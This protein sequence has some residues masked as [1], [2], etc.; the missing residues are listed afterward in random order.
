VLGR[1]WPADAADRAGE[2]AEL[3]GETGAPDGLAADALAPVALAP[4]A[5]E[6]AEAAGLDARALVRRLDAAEAVGWLWFSGAVAGL[7]VATESMAPATRQTAR[8]L[9]SSGMIVPCPAN[10]AV[11]LRTRRRRRRARS[12]RW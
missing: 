1:T 8:M 11:S 9:A 12:S 6:R 7:N 10:G 2:F 5:L 3:D 4:L